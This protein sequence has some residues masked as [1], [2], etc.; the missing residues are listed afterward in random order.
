MNENKAWLRLA[1]LFDAAE[2][3]DYSF[4]EAGP[5][6]ENQ[7]VC[8]ICDGIHD[9][10]MVGE[11]TALTRAAMQ[12]NIQLFAPGEDYSEMCFWWDV[13]SRKSNNE[14]V[15]ACCF[16]VAITDKDEDE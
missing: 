14:R 5:I 11:I 16:L 6:R 1:E 2:M 9:M 3:S 10:H 7:V 12:K 4:Y 13:N 15:L 8:G